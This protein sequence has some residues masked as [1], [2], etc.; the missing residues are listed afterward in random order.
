MTG[1]HKITESD[2]NLD[3]LDEDYFGYSVSSLGDLDG[4]GTVDLLV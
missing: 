2:P 3:V 1:Y 4:D